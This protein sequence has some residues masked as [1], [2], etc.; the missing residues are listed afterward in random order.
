MVFPLLQEVRL[1][2]VQDSLQNYVI[3]ETG[4]PFDDIDAD[5]DEAKLDN[6]EAVIDEREI[7]EFNS[8]E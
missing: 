8:D 1:K 7:D 6:N 2:Y 3:P 5:E 4:N